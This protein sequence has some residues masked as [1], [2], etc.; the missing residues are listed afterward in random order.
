MYGYPKRKNIPLV[1]AFHVCP[2]ETLEDEQK[3]VVIFQ[4]TQAHRQMHKTLE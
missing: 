4:H 3:M 2:S 1:Y